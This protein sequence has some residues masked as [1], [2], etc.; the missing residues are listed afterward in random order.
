MIEIL[1]DL[2]DQL[3]D[4]MGEQVSCLRCE[5]LV[6]FT[7][8]QSGTKFSFN[9]KISQDRIEMLLPSL[10]AAF[11]RF[12]QTI[13]HA[14]P[15]ESRRWE[16]REEI[17]IV[18]RVGKDSFLVGL[19]LDTGCRTRS[20]PFEGSTMV[21]WFR[22]RNPNLLDRS[23]ED[24]AGWYTHRRCSDR[25]YWWRRDHDGRGRCWLKNR[26]NVDEHFQIIS[27][28]SASN[29]PLWVVSF[30]ISFSRPLS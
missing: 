21:R 28:V 9:E 25:W 30:S 14:E 15:T 12:L 27:V 2:T 16:R 24:T 6:I 26:R 4:G 7:H 10:E 29:L 23:I 20:G 18:A 17:P 11:E 22:K 5:Q 13:D 19:W 1:S 3:T 8:G